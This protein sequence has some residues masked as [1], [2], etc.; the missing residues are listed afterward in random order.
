[1]SKILF[2]AFQDFANVSTDIALAVN[3]HVDGW[4]AK[5]CGCIPHP[6]CYSQGHDLDF[7]F[8]SDL[9]KREMAQW[10]REGVDVLVWAE[11]EQS[12]Y[13]YYS[14]YGPGHSFAIA[15]MFGMR[16][17]VFANAKKVIFHAGVSYREYHSVYNALDPDH[18]DA[19]LLSP[20][21]WRLSNNL[22]GISCFSKP[23]EVDMESVS[24]SWLSERAGQEIV[25]CHSPT[26]YDHKGTLTIDAAAERVSR[27]LPNVS[28][29][30][31]GGPVQDGRH[32][33]HS[34]VLEQRMSCHVYVDQFSKI[35]G[36]GVSSVEAMAGG[37]VSLCTTQMVPESVWAKN[38]LDSDSCPLIS[39]QAPT[40]DLEVDV[41]AIESVLMG[42]CLD[43][44][45]L[46][47]RGVAGAKWVEENLNPKTFADRFISSLQ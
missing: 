31:I 17:S 24:E 16:E 27:A 25:I 20:D 15:M 13:G 38:G 44:K 43:Q 34:A 8:S 26:N 12:P 45:E 21:L 28:Y 19:Q 46:V 3:Q 30:H 7:D 1:M 41:Q 42:L 2:I 39:L 40:G 29:R 22:E 6:F 18:F 23:M 32:L 5:V 4:E 10:I 14:F 9:E 47:R 37:L 35:G 33:S 36:I 11:E